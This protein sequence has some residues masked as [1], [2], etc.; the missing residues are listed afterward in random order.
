VASGDVKPL[1]GFARA[2]NIDPQWDPSGRSL[3]F[4]S[5]AAGATN[6]YRLDVGDGSLYQ[7][8]DLITGVSG[9]TALSPALSVAATADR[10]AFSVYDRSATRST[11]WGTPS[12]W[13]D[14]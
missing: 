6:I 11:P 1:P 7:L 9:I 8:T 5:D 13:P 3:Y 4:L 10:L 12:G 14:G 2:K